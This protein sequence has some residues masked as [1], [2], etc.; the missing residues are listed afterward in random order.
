MSNSQ[1]TT[2][3]RDSAVVEQA[4]VNPFA[5]GKSIIVTTQIEHDIHHQDHGPRCVSYDGDQASLS[6]YSSTKNL[7]RASHREDAEA[8]SSDELRVSR[9]SH[10]FSPSMDPRSGAHLHTEEETKLGYKATAFATKQFDGSA[11]LS[12]RPASAAT[13]HRGSHIKRAVGNEVAVA[14]LKVAF[15]MFVALFVVWVPSTCNRLYQFFHKDQPNYALNIISAIVLPLQG[16]WNATIYIYTTRS[17]CMRAYAS[18]KSKLTGKPVPSYQPQDLYRKNTSTSSGGTRD[19]DHE[20]QLEEDL[21]QGNH[22]RRCK[23]ARPDSMVESKP[24][25]IR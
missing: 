12:P 22:L 25:R 4:M 9:I 7:S 2:G 24:D 19:Y 8:T 15:L 21:E 23:L 16:A 11:T 6:S 10:D 3:Q 1:H 5:G 13:H 20:I 18:V 17:E 14:Y